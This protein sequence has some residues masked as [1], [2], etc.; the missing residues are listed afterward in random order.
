MTNYEVQR[1]WSD[2]YIPYVS[3]IIIDALKL[4][5]SVWYIIVTTP[6]QDMKEAADLIL[7]NGKEEFMIALRLRNASYMSRYPF[8]FTIRREYTAGHKTEYQKMMEG[9]ADMMFYGFRDGNKIVRWVFLLVDE[10]RNQHFH[11]ENGEWY[12]LNHIKF[13]RKDNTDGR[14]CFNGYDINS[15]ENKD[16]LITAHSAGYFEDVTVREISG[17]D[18]HVYTLKP[19]E[20]RIDGT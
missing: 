19:T 3:R 9:F 12:P 15:F 11:A 20:D 1:E 14:N 17:L 18:A 4:D 8:E 13:E 10:I 7:T 6:E 5:P 2:S 16:K